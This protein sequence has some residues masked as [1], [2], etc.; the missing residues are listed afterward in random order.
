MELKLNIKLT[1]VKEH[2]AL[3]L[4]PIRRSYFTKMKQR[5]L[6]HS[7]QLHADP[8]HCKAL[9]VI[10][11]T[12]IFMISCVK[13]GCPYTDLS[14][15]ECHCHYRDFSSKF[16][17]Q[18]NC[19]LCCP[20]QANTFGN[21]FS[22]EIYSSTFNCTCVCWGEKENNEITCDSTH[23]SEWNYLHTKR[24]SKCLCCTGSIKIF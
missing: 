21:Y 17:V 15:I 23:S 8:A 22:I 16:V 12:V 3:T 7:P 13:S 1:F 14:L 2:G 24:N 19:Q 20:A 4:L 6:H 9:E 11:H 5:A 10:S 18:S